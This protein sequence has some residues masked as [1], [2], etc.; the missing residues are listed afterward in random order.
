[1]NQATTSVLYLQA[2]VAEVFGNCVL[3]L[4]KSGHGLHQASSANGV[5]AREQ[6]TGGIDRELSG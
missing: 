4:P 2:I 6:A 1:M 5:S 3:Q